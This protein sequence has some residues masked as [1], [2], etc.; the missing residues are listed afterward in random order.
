ML[1]HKKI[2]LTVQ[3]AITTQVN[4]RWTERLNEDKKV[5]Q[6]EEHFLKGPHQWQ[7][8]R[9]GDE[10]QQWSAEISS[11]TEDER[12]RVS[13]TEKEGLFSLKENSKNNNK[14]GAARCRDRKDM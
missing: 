8:I 1:S 2:S 14:A 13:S 9:D 12:L 11:W 3:K 4:M 7:R 10:T 5:R 6:K